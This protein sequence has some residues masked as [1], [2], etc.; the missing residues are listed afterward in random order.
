MD[1]AWVQGW[2][3]GCEREGGAG[4]GG[5]GDT[6]SKCRPHLAYKHIKVS[7]S[8]QRPCPGDSPALDFCVLNKLLKHSEPG[9]G[10]VGS[11]LLLTDS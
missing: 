2:G 1:R 11:G 4:S 9:Q 5:P 10:R 8:G 7:L 3:S 6:D